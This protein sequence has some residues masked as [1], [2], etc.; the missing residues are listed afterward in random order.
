VTFFGH[1]TILKTKSWNPKAIFASGANGTL[2]VGLLDLALLNQQFY[3]I[4]L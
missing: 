4:L 2:L 1:L 3:I